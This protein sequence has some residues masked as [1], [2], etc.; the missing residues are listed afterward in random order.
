MGKGVREIKNTVLGISIILI[1]ITLFVLINSIVQVLETR[2]MLQAD[3]TQNE[4]TAL[5]EQTIQVL[6][7]LDSPVMIYTLFRTD[8][9]NRSEI[10]LLARIQ[11]L[12]DQYAFASN[13]VHVSNIDPRF[14]PAFAQQFDEQGRG[15][16][17]NSVIVTNENRTSFSV[18]APAE[19]FVWDEM[20]YPQGIIAEQRITT[21]ISYIQTG[22]SLRIRLLQGHNEPTI[23]ELTHLLQTFSFSIPD[24]TPY[25][26]ITDANELDPNYDILVIINPQHDLNETE[27]QRINTFIDGGGKILACFEPNFN[28]ELAN[29]RSLFKRFTVELGDNCIHEGDAGW[30][31]QHQLNLVPDLIPIP[32]LIQPLI[33]S[34]IRPVMPFARSVHVPQTLEIEGIAALPLLQSSHTSYAKTNQDEIGM[35]KAPD[36]QQGPFTLAVAAYIDQGRGVDGNAKLVLFGNSMFLTDASLLNVPGNFSLVLNSISWLA[37]REHAISILPKFIG[38]YPFYLPSDSALTELMVILF[39]LPVIVVV[40]GIVIYFRRKRL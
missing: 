30:Y 27:M 36:D 22:M 33:D 24:V 7:S 11:R 37:S 40:I 13:N 12:I 18:F 39:T 25:N 29:F 38:S 3:L 2:F 6:E 1:T 28:Q 15:I 35:P 20:N 23:N 34:N 14:N 8:Q 26:L 21:A 10:K 5:S 31:Y 4:I 32:L 9:T 17:E 19:L 16:E